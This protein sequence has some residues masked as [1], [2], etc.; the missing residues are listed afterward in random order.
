[1]SKGEEKIITLLQKGKYKFEREKRFYDLKKGQ[2]RY[3]FYLLRE[4][5]P[6]LIEF[7]G[8]QHYQ[9]IP[10]FYHC[11]ADFESAKE[12]DRRKISYALAKEI[13]LYIIPYWEIDNLKSSADIFKLE[14]LAKTRWK[15]DQDWQRYQNLTERFKI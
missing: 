9:Y 8:E 7:Q 11:R 12:R 13:P 6:V 5:R 2:Y 15:N 4:G 1:M 3:D 14:F 10:K